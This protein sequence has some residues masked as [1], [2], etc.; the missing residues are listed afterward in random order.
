MPLASPAG[1]ADPAA[2]LR[3]LEFFFFRNRLR[4]A[5]R[6]LKRHR[7]SNG[8]S[9]ELEVVWEFGKEG[10]FDRDSKARR[11][12]LEFELIIHHFARPDG[13]MSINDVLRLLAS[14]STEQVVQ[15]FVARARL[16]LDLAALAPRPLVTAPGLPPMT[17]RDA[18]LDVCS[19]IYLANDLQARDLADALDRTPDIREELWRQ[20]HAYALDC[21]NIL[22][23]VDAFIDRERIWPRATHSQ[24]CIFCR[25]DQQ[26]KSVEH[27]APESLGNE[28]SL[29]P[30]GYVCT[31]CNNAF[32][33]VEQHVM[34]TLPMSFLK[35]HGVIVDK[36]GRLPSVNY[37]KVHFEKT[38]PNAVIVRPQGRRH[39]LR[40]VRLPDGTLRI[41]MPKISSR[42]DHISVARLLAKMA[43]GA[44]AIEQGHAA[45][46]A[47]RYDAVR[48]FARSGGTFDN[49]LLLGRNAQ[50]GSG[51]GIQWLHGPNGTG[52]FAQASILGAQ[53]AM[54]I[55][56]V[57]SY[58][59]TPPAPPADN[60]WV[61]F[62]LRR[63]DPGP[64]PLVT[65]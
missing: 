14:L 22:S 59:G 32:S 50:P 25:S 7:E 16:R 65:W 40:E 19:R 29:L 47:P 42:F 17:R 10:P 53:V 55:E 28:T 57:T 39:Q 2:T 27:V 3:E 18:F 33:A 20:A 58:S 1:E 56:P 4:K 38:S 21:Y 63:T 6:A 54:G 45:A 9:V 46:L 8:G 23:D 26:M 34:D 13:L 51:M 36:N 30:R 41:P 37:A 64:H 24:E 5:T 52:T 62:S 44:I 60:P 43:L 15:H 12:A 49:W 61:T 31:P 35:F 11:A 48:E